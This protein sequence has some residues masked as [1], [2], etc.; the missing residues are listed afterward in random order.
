MSQRALVA[1]KRLVTT[2]EVALFFLI[3]FQNMWMVFSRETKPNLN[4]KKKICCR[5]LGD[6]LYK[7]KK[8]QTHP[9]GFHHI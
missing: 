7:K 8:K 3:S 9:S 4:T 1:L 2:P 5:F 6:N